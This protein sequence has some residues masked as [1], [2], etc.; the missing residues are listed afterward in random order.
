LQLE[1]EY[2][3]ALKGASKPKSPRTIQKYM[4]SLKSLRQSLERHGDP[5]ELGSITAF[6]VTRWLAELR[7]KGLKED[8]LA[9]RL[10]AVKTFIR[11][12][13][14]K[15]SD[16]THCDLLEKVERF[17]PPQRLKKVLTQAELEMVLDSFDDRSPTHVRDRAFIVTFMATGLRYREILELKLTEFDRRTGEFMV[18]AKGDKQR[19]AQISGRALRYVRMCMC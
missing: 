6:T 12:F 3:Q 5:L 13:V 4:E 2:L 15:Q 17:Q 16:M 19:P 8:T 1:A 14:M 7:K 10:S 18:I 11:K 9:P